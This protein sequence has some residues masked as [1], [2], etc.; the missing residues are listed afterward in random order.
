MIHPAG[1]KCQ[2]VDYLLNS[3]PCNFR[4]KS[5]DKT[6]CFRWPEKKKSSPSA[7][8]SA[9]VEKVETINPSIVVGDNPAFRGM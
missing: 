9:V 5:L 2:A 8:A 6:A 4:E 1:M 3:S 7:I